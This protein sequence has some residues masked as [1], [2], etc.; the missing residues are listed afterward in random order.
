MGASGSVESLTSDI[1]GVDL[2]G[3][4]VATPRGQSA[5]AEVVRL[6]NLL[7]DRGMATIQAIAH[8]RFVEL[9]V[10][11]SGFLENK[12]LEAV[13]DWVMMYF[14][15]KFGSDPAVVR[16]KIMNR[17]DSNRDGKLDHL[18]F[19]G[20]FMMIL[21]RMNLLERA[22]KKFEELDTD[23][24]NFLEAG[25]IHTVVD[26]TLQAYPADDDLEKYRSKM[27]AQ[28]DK[29]GDGKLDL[30]EFTQLFEEMLVRMDLIHRAR[31]KFEALD[32]DKSGM[33]EVA[34]LDAVAEWVLQGYSDKPA[35]ER[36]HFK[37]TLM[38]RIDVNADGKLS[39]QEFAVVFDE[40]LVRMDL[41][42][43]AKK[44]FHKLDTDGSGFLEKAELGAVL[45]V[46][47]AAC[48]AEVGVD[49]T[50]SM[51]ELL[52]KTDANAD[53]KLELSEFIPLFDQVLSACG[54]WE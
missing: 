13:T 52:A 14:G 53:G 45:K 40:I 25:E 1:Q 16:K 12:E 2:T 42:E 48:G 6:R 36:E 49:P 27:L 24:S 31:A 10:D 47:A 15:D 26:W 17:L 4:D 35:E 23:K 5:R 50:A 34:E 9:D 20:L 11:K 7:M 32:T 54:I 21:Q 29:N 28:V 39:M 44:Q 22:R 38:K 8:A 46:W 18:E 51:E 30:I 37:A 3:A 19:Q 41:H 33:L 43:R